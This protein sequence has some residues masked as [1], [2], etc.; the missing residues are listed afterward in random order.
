MT[1]FL[2]P[3]KPDTDPR[4]CR[5]CG[6]LTLTPTRRAGMIL[7]WIVI[8]ALLCYIGLDVFEDGKL[9]GSLYRAVLRT[10]SVNAPK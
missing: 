6:H 1:G 7:L 8:G 9:D 10:H 4:R 3:L 5:V 2:E